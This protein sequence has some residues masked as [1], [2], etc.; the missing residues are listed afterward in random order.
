MR[1]WLDPWMMDASRCFGFG[2][3]STIN[4][5]TANNYSHVYIV[6]MVTDAA[7]EEEV[8]LL[9]RDKESVSLFHLYMYTSYIDAFVPC[10]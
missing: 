7:V 4:A 6:T 8:E 3:R 9:M 2:W 1:D 5:I 10:V